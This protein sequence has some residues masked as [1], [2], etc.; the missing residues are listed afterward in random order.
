MQ[1]RDI[2]HVPISGACPDV[3]SRRALGAADRRSARDPRARAYARTRA[4]RAES[5]GDRRLARVSL[6]RRRALSRARALR[7]LL[8][9]AVRG[10]RHRHAARARRRRGGLEGLRD[11]RTHPRRPGARV[12]G[13]EAR[14]HG[15][16]EGAIPAEARLGRVAGRVRADRGRVRLRLRRDAHDRVAAT[17]TSTS[18]TAPS[19]SSRTQPWRTCTRSLPRRTRKPVTPGS[20][21]SSS[22]PARRASRSP[23]S[24][25]RWGSPGRPPESSSSRTPGSPPPTSSARK[26]RASRSRCACSIARGRVL[27]R[28]D[29]ASPRAPPTMRSSTRARGRRWASRSRSTS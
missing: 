23:D 4:H 25:R 9:R 1:P 5:R 22:K 24:S 11:E 17:A 12:A 19:A 10:H 14:G 3:D 27:R 20:R 6:G 21:P 26:A 16:A 7:P 18:W 29:S 13:A 2:G 28:R 15:R 8:R